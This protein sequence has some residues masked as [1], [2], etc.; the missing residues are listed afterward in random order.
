MGQLDIQLVMS[1]EFGAAV[2]SRN[3]VSAAIGNQPELRVVPKQ[4]QA[5]SALA[6]HDFG[7]T[8]LA[9]LG[10]AAGVAAVKGIFQVLNTVVR[11]AFE[12]YRQRQAQK[13]PAQKKDVPILVLKLGAEEQE[14]DL[15]KHL[16]EVTARLNELAAKAAGKVADG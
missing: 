9:I 15:R 3:S 10:T 11:E 2:V 14:I 6:Y 8:A 4:A 5:R 13:G 7:A 16:D 12:T 1:S